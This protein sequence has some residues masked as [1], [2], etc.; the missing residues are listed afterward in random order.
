MDAA[1][2]AITARGGN[3]VRAHVFLLGAECLVA[4]ELSVWNL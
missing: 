3:L 4:Y 2:N 1:P